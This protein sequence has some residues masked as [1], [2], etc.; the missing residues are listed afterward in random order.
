M[1][2]LCRR[3]KNRNFGKRKPARYIS[4][5]VRMHSYGSNGVL[6]SNDILEAGESAVDVVD[7]VVHRLSLFV[8]LVDIIGESAVVTREFVENLAYALPG[9]VAEGADFLKGQAGRLSDDVD[10]DGAV[11]ALE[12]IQRLAVA[13]HVGRQRPIG[14]DAVVAHAEAI[15]DGLGNAGGAGLSSVA[16]DNEVIHAGES[17]ADDKIGDAGRVVSRKVDIVG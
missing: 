7:D 13:E 6:D 3:F 16:L 10:S 4:R 12:G 15:A 5:P 1:S 14:D 2:T 11:N 17:Q 8:E 9:K